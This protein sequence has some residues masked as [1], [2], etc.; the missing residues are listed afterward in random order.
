MLEDDGHDA[1]ELGNELA[2]RRETLLGI[3][4]AYEAAAL[5]VVVR[6]VVQSA[7]VAAVV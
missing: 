2:H 4:L 1:V 6:E 5:G 7:I 3:R